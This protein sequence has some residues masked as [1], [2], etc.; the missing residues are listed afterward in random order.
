MAICFSTLYQLPIPR[1]Q[2]TF[3]FPTASTSVLPPSCFTFSGS[4]A[5]TGALAG[6]LLS[7]VPLFGAEPASG[8]GSWLIGGALVVSGGGVVA[9]ALVCGALG[10]GSCAS[11][12]IGLMLNTSSRATNA[13]NRDFMVGTPCLSTRL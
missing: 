1:L 3:R 5:S 12:A 2:P 4:A 7:A 6:L 13:K 10:V 11:D 8:T 9:G